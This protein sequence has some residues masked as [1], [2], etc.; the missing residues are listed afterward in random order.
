MA[1]EQ[2]WWVLFFP[3]AGFL[4][5]AF[6]GKALIDGLDP[7]RGRSVCGAVAVIPVFVAFLV[8]LSLTVRLAQEGAGTAHTSVLFDWIHLN[9]VWIPFEFRVD[10]LSMTMVLIITGIGALIH[11]YAV[12]Y[13]AEE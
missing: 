2:I 5:Q 7:R 8:G 4:F 3:V 11:L 9:S 1:F 10:T 12:G 6:G 13:M